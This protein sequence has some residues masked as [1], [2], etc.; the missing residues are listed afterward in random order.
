MTKPFD[1]SVL[2][3]GLSFSV[4][5]KSTSGDA[6]PRLFDFGNDILMDN[7]LCH[8]DNGGNGANFF[9][10]L[11]ASRLYTVIPDSWPTGD[12]FVGVHAAYCW[13]S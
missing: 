11:G 8:R 2:T 3:S 6:Y 1:F 13:I 9:T 12:A 7:L 4:W 10:N 5:H